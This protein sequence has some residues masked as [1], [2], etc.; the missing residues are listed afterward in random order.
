METQ[1]GIGHP[2]RAGTGARPGAR[3]YM[4]N[5]DDNRI[6]ETRYFGRRPPPDHL[7]FWSLKVLD[8]RPI[9]RVR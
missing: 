9:E 8:G 6:C 2:G 3:P 4:A 7:L 5:R 1:R